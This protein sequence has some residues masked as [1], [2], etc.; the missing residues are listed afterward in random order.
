MLN[1]KKALADSYTH[2]WN[3]SSVPSTKKMDIDG[4][5]ANKRKKDSKRTT[6]RN[7]TK[8]K[9]QF[10]THSL[11]ILCKNCVE[12]HIASHQKPLVSAPP[13]LPPSCRNS[14]I[15][16]VTTSLQTILEY[17]ARLSLWL[18]YTGKKY[19]QQN[20][21]PP[22]VSN[23]WCDSI[24]VCNA[25]FFVCMC[26]LCECVYLFFVLSFELY[27]SSLFISTYLFVR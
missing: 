18:L 23:W 17:I 27:Y 24:F 9:Q 2:K 22:S 6:K 15:F 16:L 12:H 10:S 3:G 4:K 13:S 19:E 14:S 25:Q 11:I 8:L 5:K 7:S 20:P 1:H 21:T 26:M